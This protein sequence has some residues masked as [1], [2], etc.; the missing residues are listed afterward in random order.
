M[1]KHTRLIA[2]LTALMLV[3]AACAGD[4]ETADDGDTGDDTT[5]TTEAA[6]DTT[7]AI[8]DKTETT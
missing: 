4:S 5:A 1:L 6:T 2:L 3:I 8:D 7:E